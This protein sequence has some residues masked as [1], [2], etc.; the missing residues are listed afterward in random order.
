MQNEYH[1]TLSILGIENLFNGSTSDY[2][3]NICPFY[4]EC[5]GGLCD[6]EEVLK[7]GDKIIIDVV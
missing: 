3:C 7:K 2:I 1:I 5:K 6:L 4:R